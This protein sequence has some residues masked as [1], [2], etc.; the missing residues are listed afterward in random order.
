MTSSD[1]NDSR[2]PT[3][4]SPPNSAPEK[5]LVLFTVRM[6]YMVLMITASILPFAGV[7][8]ENPLQMPL[9][10]SLAPF[11]TTIAVATVIVL[12]DLRTP[13]K[14][15]S[16]VVAMYLAILAGLL[17]AI[18]IA[19]LIDLIANVWQLPESSISLKYLTLLKLA[20]GI[21]LCYLAVSIVLT[22]RD[23][24]RLV[25]PYV[26]FSKQT[27]GIRPMLLDTSI[28]IDGRFNAFCKSGFLDAPVVVPRFVIEE[29][30]RLADSSDR[31]KR[32]RGRRGLDNLQ[33][34]QEA[35][36]ISMT[37]EEADSPE[38]MVDQELIAFAQKEQLRLVSTDSNLVRV[39]EIRKVPTLN[40]HDL[41]SVMQGQVAPGDTMT[42]EILRGGETK[43]QGISYLPDGTMVVVEDGGSFIGQ[44][45]EV[46]VSN[47]LQTSAGRMVFAKAQPPSSE[48]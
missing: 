19:A 18:A 5:P 20:T 2:G 13:R 3:L 4:D 37:I 25:I 33:R 7:A 31:I 41:A 12:L 40:L 10:D 45:L 15:L 46:T 6:I 32:E 21:T 17:A 11:L 16:V 35:R 47:M 1:R 29:L 38:G 22:T 26:E 9:L 43:G 44:T 28:L 14:Q 48:T 42:L 39:A 24:I 8:G 36:E 34:L 23:D 27:R 30:H